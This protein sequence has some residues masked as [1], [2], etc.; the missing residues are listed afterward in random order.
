MTGQTSFIL[1]IRTKK[2]IS[3]IQSLT[4]DNSFGDLKKLIADL[5]GV[6]FDLIKI[7]RGYPPKSIECQTDS[8]T[9]ASLHLKT[10]DL[11][12]VEENEYTKH[13]AASQGKHMNGNKCSVLL[14]KVVPADNSCL[15]TSV[16][17]VINDAVY[18][19][20]CQKSM[21]ELI[22][23][24]VKSDPLTYTE[25]FLGNLYTHRPKTNFWLELKI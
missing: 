22:A 25:A 6:D 10:G 4:D 2:G 9:L 11:L 12:T 5:I 15:F 7:L 23:N 20:N 17:Y 18:D 14:R 13:H 1:R 3:R 8:A 21:R 19:S 24:T 16:H